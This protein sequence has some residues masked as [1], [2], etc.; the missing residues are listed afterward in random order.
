MLIEKHYT[1]IFTESPSWVLMFFS[2]YYFMFLIHIW[3]TFLCYNSKER[4]RPE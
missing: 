3:I 1:L 4:H 2:E